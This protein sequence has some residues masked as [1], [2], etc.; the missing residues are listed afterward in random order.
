MDG[1]GPRSSIEL[2]KDRARHGPSPPRPSSTLL[3]DLPEMARET[4]KRTMTSGSE[5]APFF[6]FGHQDFH[7]P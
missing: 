5:T 2:G 3:Q 4:I 1:T 6:P 7:Q